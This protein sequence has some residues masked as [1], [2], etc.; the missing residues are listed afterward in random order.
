MLLA[1]ARP[2]MFYICLVLILNKYGMNNMLIFNG[3]D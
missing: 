2:T 1:Y 3:K